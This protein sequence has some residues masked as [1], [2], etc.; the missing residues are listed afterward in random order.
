M[1]I[2]DVFTVETLSVA[3]SRGGKTW[4]FEKFP[5]E[6]ILYFY[7]RKLIKAKMTKKNLKF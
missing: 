5:C 1:D 4:K 3:L 7:A 6:Q 2:V